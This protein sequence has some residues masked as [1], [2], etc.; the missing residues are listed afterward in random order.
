MRLRLGRLLV[1]P[2]V[3]LLAVSAGSALWTAS[4][5][6]ASGQGDHSHGPP[7]YGPNPAGS[8]SR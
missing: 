7:P 3:L 2:V 6:S 5:A 1:A 8:W 4:P